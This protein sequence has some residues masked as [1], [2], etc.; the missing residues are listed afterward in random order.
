MGVKSELLIG[1]IA[2]T[3]LV[4]AEIPVEVKELLNGTDMILHAGDILEMS[5]VHELSKIAPVVAVKGN[6]DRSDVMREL[7]SR[8]VIEVGDFKIGL[9]HGSD[10]PSGIVDR[11]LKEFDKV[12]CIVFG[13]THEPVILEKEGVLFFNPGSPTDKIFAKRNSLGFL[14][15]DEKIVPRL[16][17]IGGADSGRR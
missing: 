8:R 7:P 6:M 4:G 9:T 17:E 15:I 3:H 5:L 16:V 11:V 1:V 2:D 14:E 13:H 10:G 12:D